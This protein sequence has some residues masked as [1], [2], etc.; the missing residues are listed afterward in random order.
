REA[1]GSAELIDPA[2]RSVPPGSL[3]VTLAFLGNHRSDEVEAIADAVRE[4]AAP[5]ALLKL[6][7]PIPLPRHKRA[8]LFALPTPSPATAELR[9]GLVGRLGAEGLPEA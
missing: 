7:D 5:A 8:S 2:L 3:H 1:W 9:R 6:E 4:S